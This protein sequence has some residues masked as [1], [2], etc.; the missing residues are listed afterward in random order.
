MLSLHLAERELHVPVF[1][2][3]A[4]VPVGRA[5]ASAELAGRLA[6]LRTRAVVY[7]E[8]TGTLLLSRQGYAGFR[9]YAPGDSPRRIAWKAATRGGPLL[10]TV[11]EC[12]SINGA[13]IAGLTRIIQEQ[14]AR[15]GK[16]AIAC[17]P[18]NFRRVFEAAG[19][20]ALASLH[21]SEEDGLRALLESKSV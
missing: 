16:T 21:A 14:D 18:Q 12:A 1:V 3:P 11:S 8:P 17:K 7:D 19:L 5:F 4:E 2:Q 9:L 20:T 10:V 15:G 13:G 6:L